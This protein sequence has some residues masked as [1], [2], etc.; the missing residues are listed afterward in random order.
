MAILDSRF[1]SSSEE[2][3]AN[4]AAMAELVADLRRRRAQAA[5]GGSAKARERHKGRGKLL[6]RER[7]AQLIDPGSPFLE[8]SPMAAHGMYG[9]AIHAAGILTGIGRIGAANASSCATTPR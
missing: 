3:R 6:P 1:V 2:A 8:L 7:V 9:E 5:E 4:A